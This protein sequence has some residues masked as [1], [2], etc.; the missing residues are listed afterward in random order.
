MVLFTLVL[1]IRAETLV[2]NE[3]E[4]NMIKFVVCVV[5]TP[6]A[7]QIRRRYSVLSLLLKVNAAVP[8]S[9]CKMLEV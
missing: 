7:M 8:E 9:E 1:R 3:L 5:R 6:T 2:W 4:K